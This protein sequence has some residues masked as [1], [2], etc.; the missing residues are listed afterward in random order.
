MQTKL[1]NPPSRVTRFES[2]PSTGCPA[3]PASRAEKPGVTGRARE[4][5]SPTD[6]GKSPGDKSNRLSG[7]LLALPSFPSNSL[8]VLGKA[9]ASLGGPCRFMEG[10]G[11]FGEGIV[12]L[13]WGQISP[14][15]PSVSRKSVVAGPLSPGR[16]RPPRKDT[17]RNRT[18]CKQ[19]DLGT[20][21]FLSC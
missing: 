21:G 4:K 20:D 2:L 18:V 19:H 9:N 7:G 3:R 12:P 5:A 1:T 13:E 17:Y 8:A 11:I 10:A 16:D 6:L 15:A 14:P